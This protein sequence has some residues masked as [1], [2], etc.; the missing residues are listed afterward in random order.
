MGQHI[1]SKLGKQ[2]GFVFPEGYNAYGMQSKI[3]DTNI[4]KGYP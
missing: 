1:L 2:I 4:S 3:T